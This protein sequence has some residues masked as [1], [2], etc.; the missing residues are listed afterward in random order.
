[1][2]LNS[3]IYSFWRKIQ[4]AL[5]PESPVIVSER[6]YSRPR[7]SIRNDSERLVAE[8]FL[9]PVLET[10]ARFHNQHRSLP[11]TVIRKRQ[12]SFQ[13]SV[14]VRER[15]FLGS[16]REW[17][18]RCLRPSDDRRTRSKRH[19][20]RHPVLGECPRDD[21][22]CPQPFERSVDRRHIQR[23]STHSIPRHLNRNILRTLIR[24][25]KRGG[26]FP[27]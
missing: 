4:T 22:P 15:H 9:V 3:R 8:H 19:R 7:E 25:I 20:E 17:P 27:Y 5:L 16:I 21:L 11:V 6:G 14:P 23:D 13:H 26:L 18:H 10:A 12:R 2:L 1:M 24:H